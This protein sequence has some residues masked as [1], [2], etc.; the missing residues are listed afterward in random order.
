MAAGIMAKLGTEAIGGAIK[1]IAGIAGGLIGG[2]KRRREQAAAQ[3]ELDAAK[4]Q[5][6]AIDTS[7]PYKNV[8]NTFED[9]TVNTQAADFAAQQ[10]QQGLANIMG[11]LAGSAGGGGVAA[12]AQSLANQQTQ[13]AQQAAASIGAQEAQNQQLAARGEQQAQMQRAQGEALSRQ[14]QFKKGEKMMDMAQQRLEQAKAARAA[15]TS[16]LMGGVGSLMG[17]A[18]AGAKDLGFIG[19]Q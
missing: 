11:G 15:A 9:L 8:T 17:G 1:G 16:G 13:A 7:N 4:S 5:Y 14:M 6:A 10:Q 12:L 19:G 2:R 3:R 18:V